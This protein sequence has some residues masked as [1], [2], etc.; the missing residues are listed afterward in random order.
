MQR[1][2]EK[3][4]LFRQLHHNGML[5]LPNIWDPLGAALLEKSGY[6]AVAT[7]SASVAFVNG[8]NDGENIPFT[9]LLTLLKKITRSVNIP[10]TAD[11][12]SGFANNNPELK[13]NIQSLIETGIAGINIEDTDKKSNELFA[14]ETQCERIKSIKSVADEA[15][16]PLFINARTDVYIR[17]K[18]LLNE[19]EKFN[20]TVKRGRAYIDAG[21]DCF[22]PIGMTQKTS[23]KNIIA[24]LNC[25]VNILAI[26]G[27][28]ALKT[29]RETGVARVS[30]GPGFLKIAIKKLKETAEKLKVYEGLEEI[31]G[32]EVT[33][34]FLKSLVLK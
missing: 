1:Q 34:D 26:P 17:R 33:T 22:F 8:Y 2:K 20:E 13:K 5:L 18:D 24:Q 12:E 32:N 29:L 23:I 30:L 15:G 28:P 31:T 7:A 3:A 27:I 6:P 25:P 19:E 16:M 10:V 21:G 9:D 11:V 4:E 14:V